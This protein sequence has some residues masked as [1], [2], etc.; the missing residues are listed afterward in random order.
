VTVPITLLMRCSLELN[1]KVPVCLHGCGSYG[2]NVLAGYS[3]PALALADRGWICALAQVRGG[4]EKG[5]GWRHSVL[6]T[7]KKT[8]FIDFIAHLQQ[9]AKFFAF[10]IWSVVLRWR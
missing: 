3:A 7:G 10:A 4:G 2:D 6:K 8:T 9:E 1:G 5:I